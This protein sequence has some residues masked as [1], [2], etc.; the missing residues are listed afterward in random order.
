LPVLELLGAGPPLDDADLTVTARLQAAHHASE[1]IDSRRPKEDPIVEA[2][3]AKK[4]DPGEVR[5][6]EHRGARRAAGNDLLAEAPPRREGIIGAE[7]VDCCLA[8]PLHSGAVGCDER[9]D[10]ELVRDLGVRG[11]FVWRRV[12]ARGAD[13]VDVIVRWRRLGGCRRLRWWRFARRRGAG[14][15]GLVVVAAGRD[16]QHTE[17]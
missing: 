15:R 7:D 2:M 5:L 6:E 13:V 1:E 17:E 10:P 12:L 4:V 14:R 11:R 9:F 3:R 8:L 16:H